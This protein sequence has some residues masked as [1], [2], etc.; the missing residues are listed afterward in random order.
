MKKIFFSLILLS[1]IPSE[2]TLEGAAVHSK[3]ASYSGW[4]KE[5]TQLVIRELKQ[6]GK[7]LIQQLKKKNFNK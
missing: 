4:W 6:K 3:P 7:A 2:K 5:D 1:A